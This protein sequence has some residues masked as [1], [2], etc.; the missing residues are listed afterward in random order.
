MLPVLRRL[1]AEAA[2]LRFEITTTNSIEAGRLA[3]AGQVA[4]LAGLEVE[5][6]EQL[7][8]HEKCS[9]VV[10]SASRRTS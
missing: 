9:S 8:G 2:P 10:V 7:P 5:I 1:F 4:W 6:A 3:S